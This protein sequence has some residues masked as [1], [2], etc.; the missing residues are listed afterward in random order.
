MDEIVEALDKNDF[1]VHVHAI[2]DRAI[3]VALNAFEHAIAV[4]GRND[5]R[6]QIAHLELIRPSD[7]PRFRKLGVTANFEGLW[8][9]KDPY[10]SECTEPNLGPERSQRLYQ[11]RTVFN[12]GAVIS[13]GSDWS[14][15]SLNPL[16]AIQ[17]AVT[18]LGLSDSSGKPWLPEERM[19]LSEMIAAYTINGAY[20][21][22]EEKLNGSLECGKA[23]D[24]IVLD[25]NLFDV[26][27][28][29]IHNVRV[30][31]TY[32]NGHEVFTAS[33]QGASS[34]GDK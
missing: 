32:L 9:Y 17:V 34:Q 2:G 22:H 12:T 6:H 25:K 27:V 18:R 16:D 10:I 19:A 14:V 7:I 33:S 23:A 5:H 20:A 8:A 15:T 4:N 21:N 28:S 29:E 24:F 11:I 1:Q 26:P 13:A 31:S 3:N 30:I